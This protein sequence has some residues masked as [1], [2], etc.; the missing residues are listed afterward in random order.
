MAQHLL[1]AA[2]ELAFLADEDSINRRLHVVV[3]A[4]LAGALEEPERPVMRVEHHLLGFARIG[5]DER[6]PAVAEPD[7]GNLH[8]RA[9]AV[10]H[11]DLVAPVELVGFTGRKH[12]RNVGFGLLLRLTPLPGP[13]EPAH[14]IVAATISGKPQILEHQLERHTLALR[15]LRILFEHLGKLIGKAAELRQWLAPTLVTMLR[16]L[17]THDRAHRVPR[18]PK[19]PRNLLDLLALDVKSVPYPANRL[20]RNHP[21]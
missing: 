16:L 9:H 3:D 14:R 12:Q 19:L 2:V 1:E 10:D 17:A 21:P 7:M 18:K 11:D 6:H 13:A 8:R 4:T 15:P 5:P 20:H